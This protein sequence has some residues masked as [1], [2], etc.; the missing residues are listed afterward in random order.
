MY[1]LTG[2]ISERDW[3][4]GEERGGGGENKSWE[5]LCVA[6]YGMTQLEIGW[7]RATLLVFNSQGPFNSSRYAAPLLH[8]QVDTYPRK[9]LAGPERESSTVATSAHTSHIT[10]VVC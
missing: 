10:R 4:I 1:E 2:E 5:L 9:A 3:P 7:K 8:L 6:R